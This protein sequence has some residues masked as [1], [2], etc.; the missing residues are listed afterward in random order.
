MDTISGGVMPSGGSVKL[1]VDS[2]KTGYVI[3]PNGVLLTTVSG[4]I[5]TTYAGLEGN[6]LYLVS[7]NTNTASI[8]NSGVQGGVVYNGLNILDCDGNTA[9]TSIV[10]NNTKTIY[11]TGDSLTAKAMGDIL[12]NLYD[13]D[14]DACELAFD[15]GTNAIE[16]AVD[17]YLQS[18]YSG[19]TY[20]AVYARLYTANGGTILT[21]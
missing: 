21:N 2:D 1:T 11:A 10:A 9:L 16:G 14:V 6:I 18:A 17:A 3:L 7:K 4:V 8:A 19:L 15:E 12:K 20:A 5:N 13:L